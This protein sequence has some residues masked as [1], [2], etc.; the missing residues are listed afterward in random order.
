MKINESILAEDLP[1]P[2]I[3]N[4][5][6]QYVVAANGLFIRAEDSRLEALVKVAAARLTGLADLFEGANLK[7]DRVPGVWLRSVLASARKRMPNEAMYQFWWDGTSHNAVTR[8][9]RCSMPAQISSPTALQFDDLGQTVID[10][11]SHNSMP[12]FF[13]STDD[14]DEQGL[15]FYA[16]IGRI[17]TDQPEIRVRVG[18]YGHFLDVPADMV[19]DDLGPFV[20]QMGEDEADE[21]DAATDK[22]ILLSADDEVRREISKCANC[23]SAV[24]IVFNYCP[25]CGHGFQDEESD[26][27]PDEPVS[28]H[29]LKQLDK[30]DEYPYNR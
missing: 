1:L 15:R 16:V 9:W 28:E 17:D 4:V 14:A 13:S 30:L 27:A 6:Y 5:M 23:G 19:F 11:H 24:P 21:V 29:Y 3:G 2:E 25:D 7:I 20:D 8:T 22:I 26:S 10:L 12:A 18:V